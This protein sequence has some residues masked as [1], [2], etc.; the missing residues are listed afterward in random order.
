MEDGGFGENFFAIIGVVFEQRGDVAIL[1][2]FGR[3]I[4]FEVAGAGGH[5]PQTKIFFLPPFAERALQIIEGFVGKRQRS[6]KFARAPPQIFFGH[7]VHPLTNGDDVL[8]GLNFF[9]QIPE[10]VIFFRRD[11]FFDE[12]AAGHAKEHAVAQVLGF[13]LLDVGD[14]IFGRFSA[15]GD[16]RPEKFFPV[17]KYLL[18]IFCGN[19]FR[20][21]RFFVESVV[22]ECGER[23]FFLDDR[24]IKDASIDDGV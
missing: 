12:I 1:E 6:I 14:K 10:G 3:E 7:S 17:E 22:E 20:D 9:V 24:K 15:V 18:K 19:F 23:N 11:K 2:D 5:I 16:G 13:S 21:E 8:G 4:I